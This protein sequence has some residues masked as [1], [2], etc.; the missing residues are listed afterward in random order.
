M[1]TVEYS[2]HQIGSDGVQPSKEKVEAVAH[3]PT[4][5]ENDTQVRQFLGLVNYCR[6]FVGPEFAVLAEPLTQLLRKGTQFV[7]LEEHTA[8]VQA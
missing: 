6:N 4:R 8:A 7:W 5:L 3:W 2:G 1:Q